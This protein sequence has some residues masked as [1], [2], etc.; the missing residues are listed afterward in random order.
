MSC[1]TSPIADLGPTL[2]VEADSVTGVASGDH[3]SSWPEAGP[4]SIDGVPSTMEGDAIWSAD[5]PCGMPVVQFDQTTGLWFPGNREHEHNSVFFPGGDAV[6]PEFELSPPSQ[7]TVLTLARIANSGGD[8]DAAF[9]PWQPGS[10]DLFLYPDRVEVIGVDSNVRAIDL[11]VAHAEGDWALIELWGEGG[12]DNGGLEPDLEPGGTLSLRVN[13]GPVQSMAWAGIQ[14]GGSDLCQGYGTS[15]DALAEILA[16]LIFPRALTEAER[17]AIRL[18][19]TCRYP[20][21]Q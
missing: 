21:I 16:L 2:W 18:Y 19:F 12:R 10:L 15:G 1:D 14:I 7:F 5:G 9:V 6:D 17:S 20:C 13:G 3:F 8:P 4:I 11:S